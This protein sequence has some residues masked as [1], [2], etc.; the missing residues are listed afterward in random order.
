MKPPSLIHLAIVGL[1]ALSSSSPQAPPSSS[2]SSSLLFVVASKRHYTSLYQYI[3]LLR[4]FCHS[5]A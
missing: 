2:S 1:I 3:M 4:I 5:Q